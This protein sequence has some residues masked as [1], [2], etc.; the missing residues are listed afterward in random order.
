[1][2]SRSSSRGGTSGPG[3]GPRMI[4]MGWYVVAPRPVRTRPYAGSAMAQAVMP[5]TPSGSFSHSATWTAQ[6]GR[7]SVT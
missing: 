6:S 3:R 1:M 5:P 2:R 7:P 4:D